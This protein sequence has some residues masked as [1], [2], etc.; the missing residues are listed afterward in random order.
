MSNVLRIE[1]LDGLAAYAATARWPAGFAVYQRGAPADGVFLVL[2]GRVVLRTRLRGGRAF[3][4]RVCG[5]GELFGAEGISCGGADTVGAVY[6]TDA[7]AECETHTL[8]LGRERL[9]TLLRERPSTALALFGQ[10]GVA[11]AQL[12]ERLRE[13]SMMSVE[14][15]LLAAVDRARALQPDD[16]AGSPLVFDAAGYRLLCEMVGATRESVSLVINRLM[17]E[18]LAE[19]DG[20]RVVINPSAQTADGAGAEGGGA[21]GEGRSGQRVGGRSSAHPAHPTY[22][23]TGSTPPLAS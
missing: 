4:P 14:Q 15:R 5:P 21:S 11:H 3:V 16:I 1:E 10:V 18:G 6:E 2:Q 19:R 20:A 12:L 7:R 13:L 22:H 9:R 8:H 17:D 23:E